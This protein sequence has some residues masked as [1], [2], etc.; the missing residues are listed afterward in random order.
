M[1]G[2]GKEEVFMKNRGLLIIIIALIGISL[3]LPASSYAR[4][5]GWGRGYGWV[6]AGAFAGGLLLG[7]AI[8]RPYYARA[9]MYVYPAP[10]VVYAAPPVYAPNQAYAYPDPAITSGADNGP[11]AGQWVEVPGQYV[12]GRWVAPHKAWAPNNP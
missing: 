7:T 5:R 8:A 4:G 1:Q 2:D 10:A 12:G 3:A 6:G 11:S 9:P